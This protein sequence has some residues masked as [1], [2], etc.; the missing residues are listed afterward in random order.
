MVKE[1]YNAV[2][3]GEFIVLSLLVVLIIAS[4]ILGIFEFR[5]HLYDSITLKELKSIRKTL[6][7]QSLA[8]PVSLKLF[9]YRGGGKLP[10]PLDAIE[11]KRGVNIDYLL[12]AKRGKQTIIFIG[13][14]HEKSRH[15]FRWLDIF[16]KRRLQ[17][18]QY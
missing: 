4:L 2:S 14:S 9:N 8:S 12:S 5:E 10:A 16:G 3:L 11:V 1:R 15:R 7:E 6:Y 18:I 13:L 17:K